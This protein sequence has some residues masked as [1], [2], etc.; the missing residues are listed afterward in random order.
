MIK[1]YCKGLPLY[2][3]AVAA[4]LLVHGLAQHWDAQ[5]EAPQPTAL[6]RHT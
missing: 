3:A 5:S 1:K 2:I 4:T 6:V